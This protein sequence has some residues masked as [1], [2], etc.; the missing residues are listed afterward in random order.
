[1]RRLAALA[2]AALAAL[3]AAAQ[4][5]AGL[6]IGRPLFDARALGLPMSQGYVGGYHVQKWARAN[7]V[8]LSV[9]GVPNGQIVYMESFPGPTTPAIPGEGLRFKVTSMG[10]AIRMLGGPGFYF[11]GRGPMATTGGNDVWFHSYSLQD[12]PNVIVTFAFAAPVSVRGYNPDG[13]QI[14]NENALLDSMIVSDYAYQLS[15]W[16]GEAVARPG[17]QQ[18]NLNYR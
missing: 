8:E 6:D 13:T 14:P 17:Y 2:L 7:G 5:F 4:E 9:T 3:P 16:G 11:T 15:I 12:R 18:I 1:M 10:E